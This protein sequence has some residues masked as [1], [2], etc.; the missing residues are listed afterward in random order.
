[1]LQPLISSFLVSG[2][3]E[4]YE[5][6]RKKACFKKRLSDIFCLITNSQNFRLC[7]I[8]DTSESVSLIKFILQ[9][10]LKKFILYLIKENFLPV[11]IQRIH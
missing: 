6:T 9:E 7:S 10:A 11:N 2:K 3:I 5:V 4:F 1:M 8:N